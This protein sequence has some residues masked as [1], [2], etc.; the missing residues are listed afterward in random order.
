[1]TALRPAAAQEPYNRA[2]KYQVD[3]FWPKQLPKNWIVG[4]IGGLTVDQHD[5]IWVLQRPSTLTVD[6]KGASLTPPRSMCC[7]PAPPVMEFDSEGN[8]VRSWGG[9]G[10]GFEWPASEHGI[11][12]D[13]QD[14]VWIGGNGPDDHQ[15]L[16]FTQDG[17]FLMQIGHAAKTGG[18]LSHEMLGRPAGIAV[19]DPNHEVYVADGY[20]NKRVIVF[21]S[22]TGAFKRLWGGHG[23]P[24]DDRDPGP[25]DPAA[26]PARQFRS[27]VHCVH[28]SHG[29]LVYVC[30]R[31]NN[32][33]QVFT[34]QGGFVKEF[35]LE[36][37]LGNGSAW[38]LTFSSDKDEAFLIVADGEDNVLWTLS[39]ND[40]KILGTTGHNGRNAGQFHWVHQ[41]AHDSKGNLY[42]GEVDTSKRLQKFVLLP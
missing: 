10:T 35:F 2:P 17:H 13:K 20:L 33:I 5:H 32:R 22:Q 30:D 25:Y 36:K 16:K 1:V 8:L 23:D 41:I 39:R 24:P 6:E 28:I 27:P 26:P 15:L 14:N 38:D 4:Q 9:P 7:S 18:S 34:K 11:Y 29:G 12:V 40:G 31:V 37:S 21:D 19:D 3:P 42:T